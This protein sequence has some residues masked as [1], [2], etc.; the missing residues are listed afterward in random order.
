MANSF[1]KQVKN[2]VVGE[3]KNAAMMAAE[4]FG[5]LPFNGH[6]RRHES[7]GVMSNLEHAA[8]IIR[9]LTR[10][11]QHYSARN[12][13]QGIEY[14]QMFGAINV[15]N[16]LNEAMKNSGYFDYANPEIGI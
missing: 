8:R 9:N 10:N 6:L 7:G 15:S 13:Y 14:N 12:P 1:G 4:S 3:L 11:V 2:I 5:P 16:H